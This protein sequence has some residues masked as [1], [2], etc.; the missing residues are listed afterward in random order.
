MQIGNMQR[1]RSRMLDVFNPKFQEEAWNLE[2]TWINTGQV[3][4]LEQSLAD[5]RVYEYKQRE[6][7]R[8]NG[9]FTHRINV[10]IK[11][12]NENAFVLLQKKAK[13]LG[14]LGNEEIGT[15][16]QTGALKDVKFSFYVFSHET[17]IV[18]IATR[19]LHSLQEGLMLYGLT[20]M[21]E[22][23]SVEPFPAP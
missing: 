10:S 16:E 7:C 14:M 5:K 17:D 23:L 1:Y 22:P 19:M 3:E 8:K 4:D 15:R 6:W 20:V 13:T 12:I 9:Q 18:T 21:A 2:M 11:V